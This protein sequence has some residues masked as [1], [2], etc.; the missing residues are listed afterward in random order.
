MYRPDHPGWSIPLAIILAGPIFIALFFIADLYLKL[1]ASIAFEPSNMLG[2][3]TNALLLLGLG[4]AMSVPIA[5]LPILFGM[6][7]MQMLVRC[8]PAFRPPVVWAIIGGPIGALPLLAF[9]PK[10]IYRPAAFALVATSAICAWLC[11]RGQ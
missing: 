8:S 5:I 1:P 2:Y 4:M 11:G 7:L 9:Q 3:A 10:D 6:A